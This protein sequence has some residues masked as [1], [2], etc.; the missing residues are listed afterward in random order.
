[1]NIRLIR[2]PIAPARRHPVAA[3]VIAGLGAVHLLL[4]A[5]VAVCPRMSM[6]WCITAAILLVAG[7]SVIAIAVRGIWLA[8]G[9]ARAVAALTH[10]DPPEPV[11]SAAMDAG[12]RGVRYVRGVDSV[13]FCAGLLRPR[14]YVTCAMATTLTPSELHAV[15]AHEAAHA[16]RR[17]P[18]RRVVTRATA[19]VL[20]YLPL[21]RWWSR[22]QTERSELHAD[23]AAIDSAGS[24]AV[25]GALLAAAGNAESPHT[26]IQVSAATA[27]GAATDARI[28][29]LAGDELPVRRPSRGQMIYS[30]LGFIGAVWLMMCLGQAAL[31]TVGI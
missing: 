8:A 25:A 17:D 7:A 6:T 14:V 10:T 11:A 18:L 16:R 9:A 3:T 28:A 2:W 21:A 12:M 15:L 23:R 27:Y 31:A 1:M 26:R 24:H 13:A 4:A 22:R 5:G 30:V 20:F 19:D 29:Q